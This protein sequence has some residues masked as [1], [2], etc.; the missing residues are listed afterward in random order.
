MLLAVATKALTGK[1]T[2]AGFT[3]GVARRWRDKIEQ[4]TEIP[5]NKVE[6]CDISRNLCAACVVDINLDDGL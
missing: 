1:R 5:L 4:S 6:S 3:G 2:I